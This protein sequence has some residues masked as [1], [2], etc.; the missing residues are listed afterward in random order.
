MTWLQTWY[1][2]PFL[3]SLFVGVG[4]IATALAGALEHESDVDHDWDWLGW[5]GV[6]RAPI[7]LLLQ[8]MLM[9]FGVTGLLVNAVIQDLLG[10]EGWVGFLI[11]CGFGGAAA[12]SS[13]FFVGWIFSFLP[14]EKATSPRPGGYVGETARASALIT[15]S[16][17]TATLNFDLESGAPPVFLNVR[18]QRGEILREQKVLLMFYDAEKRQYVVTQL[19]E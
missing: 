6:G 7:S 8:G 2:W 16:F 17:G 1:N 11:A 4:L 3:L 10:S 15:E 12:V 19:E 14:S 9:S 13:A 5:L 18:S